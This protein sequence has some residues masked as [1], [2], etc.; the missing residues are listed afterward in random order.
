MA[1]AGYGAIVLTLALALYTLFAAWRFLHRNDAASE[2][3]VR[4]GALLGAVA[5]TV[6]VA[7]LVSLLLMH[8]YGVKYVHEHV[9]R[10]LPLVYIV[11]AFW[12]GQEG[13]L[14]LW[15][16]FVSLFSLSVA[17]Q[18]R[19]W[20]RLSAYVQ[21]VMALTQAFLALV[22]L[23]ASN[24]FEKL[25]FVA[26]DGQGISPLLQNLWMVMHPPAVFAGYAAYTVPFA[27]ALGGL[28]TRQ[29][30]REWLHAV[31]RWALVAWLLLGAGI[32]MGAY[33]AYLEL[34]WGGYWNWDP[35]ENAS[36]IPWLMGTALLHSLIAQERKGI[37]RMWS[38]WLAA[39]PF[40]L[41]HFATFVTR[42]GIIR[43]VHAFLRSSLGYYFVGFILLCLATLAILA[44]SRRELSD[45]KSQMPLLGRE[46]AFF[47][48]ILL[49][50][51]AAAVLLA[52]ILFSALIEFVWGWQGALSS[53]FYKRTVGPLAQAIVF[54]IGVCPWLAW[55][56]VSIDRL[57][58]GLLPPLI[59]GL[60]AVLIMFTLGIRQGLL[61]FAACIFVTCSIASGF[62]RD[63]RSRHC[64]TGERMPLLLLGLLRSGRRRY[65]G[66]LAHLGIVLIALGVTG[67]SL[68]QNKVQIKLLP[69]ESVTIQNYTFKYNELLNEKAPLSDRFVARVEASRVGE[70]ATILAP[71]KELYHSTQQ[72]VHH[73][74]IRPSLREDLYVILTGLEQDGSANFRLLIN[75][76]AVW[77]WIGGIVLVGG[78]ALAWWPLTQRIK[79][80]G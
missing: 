3:S 61:S 59:M 32:L 5:C 64:S 77:L 62:W 34:G 50:V 71:S 38:V 37:S 24:P 45:D 44:L 63:A 31:R 60:A 70:R 53:S 35:V 51:G 9:N 29:L 48:T 80:E 19:A 42:S 13:S 76:L 73:V 7:S 1:E 40:L 74:A 16:W 65:G 55:G 41:C 69:G 30:D 25:P 22:L 52:G 57:R 72:W 43:S 66:Q 39:A 47:L 78:G 20:D 46:A 26:A 15:L 33:W 27:F 21:G 23:F 68:Y 28:A 79:Q 14:L 11:S 56:E 54:L 75:P 10:H 58:R 49:F 6:A 17:I 8:N 12:A 36:L 18:Q 67:S 4:N 2:T